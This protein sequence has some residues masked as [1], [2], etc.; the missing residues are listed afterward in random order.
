MTPHNTDIQSALKPV[1][2]KLPLDAG[3][4]G[5]PK[6]RALGSVAAI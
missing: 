1:H 6:S 3:N 4:L 5:A 2:Q